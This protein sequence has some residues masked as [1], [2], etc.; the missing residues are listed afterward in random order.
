M[1][2]RNFDFSEEFEA[3]FYGLTPSNCPLPCT[4]VSTETKHTSTIDEDF[5]FAVSFE[6]TVE[7]RFKSKHEQVLIINV[8]HFMTEDLSSLVVE[9][10]KTE[11][12][13]PTFEGFLS[14]V[15]ILVDEA[16]L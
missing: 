15:S 2:A 7:V 12:V 10:T 5:G 8:P 4:T 14:D 11:M 16:Y 3:L 1:C 13:T 6:K 9:V